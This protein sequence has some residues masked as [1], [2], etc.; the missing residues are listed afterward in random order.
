MVKTFIWTNLNP[1]H[2]K[3][4]QTWIHFTQGY[5]VSSL[6]EIGSVVLEKKM[7]MWKVYA[8]AND[9]VNIDN[10][11]HNDRQWTNFD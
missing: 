11:D 5:F 1:L 10:D 8:K 4:E 6:V 3:D 2:P 7:N 9:N